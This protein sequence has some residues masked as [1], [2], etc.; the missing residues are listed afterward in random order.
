MTGGYKMA[1]PVYILI[2][3]AIT[4]GWTSIV[5]VTQFEDHNLTCM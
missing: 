4:L 1:F 2:N 3:D 5:D